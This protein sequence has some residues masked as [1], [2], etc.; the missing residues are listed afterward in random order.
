MGRHH[1]GVAAAR[2]GCVH[3]A[4]GAVEAAR[5]RAGLG[6]SRPPGRHCHR[7]PASTGW[8][9]LDMPVPDDAWPRTLHVPP[10]KQ[11]GVKAS[12]LLFM[13]QEAKT[14]LSWFAPL[15]KSLFEQKVRKSR[16]MHAWPDSSRERKTKVG[17]GAWWG[18]ACV[19]ARCLRATGPCVPHVPW[20]LLACV[21]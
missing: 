21:G 3:G 15:G 11:D 16:C 12:L 8:T 9:C 6:W 4:P 13:S 17:V 20:L 1:S 7:W 14:Q 18:G 10:D 5:D 2:L 19:G